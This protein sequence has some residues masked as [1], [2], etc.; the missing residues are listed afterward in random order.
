MNRFV[1]RVPQLALL[2][3]RILPQVRLVPLQL[4]KPMLMIPLVQP[5]REPDRGPPSDVP[6]EQLGQNSP[7][8]HSDT[9][10][11]EDQGAGEHE[12]PEPVTN[13]PSAVAPG[14]ASGGGQLGEDARRTVQSS[15]SRGK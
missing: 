1:R 14:H 5:E 8:L 9:G 7:D 4:L 15:K 12:S 10:R 13:Q 6:N 3:L 11:L 2:D